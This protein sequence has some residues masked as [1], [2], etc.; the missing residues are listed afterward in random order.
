MGKELLSEMTSCVN[1]KKDAEKIG[2]ATDCPEESICKDIA[3]DLIKQ[4][5]GS[6]CEGNFIALI[7]GDLEIAKKEAAGEDQ[8]LD[9]PKK[10]CEVL[11]RF[12][13]GQGQCRP[14]GTMNPELKKEM[15]DKASEVDGMGG[16]ARNAPQMEV[17][18]VDDYVQE[19][20]VTI[21]LSDGSEPEPEEA[22]ED[23]I[24]QKCEELA[25]KLKTNSRRL[26]DLGVSDVNDVTGT[27]ATQTC[28]ASDE[29]CQ[30]S[31]LDVEDNN[32]D[33]GSSYSGTDRIAISFVV[34]MVAMCHIVLT[35]FVRQF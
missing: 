20:T 33:G 14:D 13:K 19:A 12:K 4:E 2:N 34:S 25:E 8:A 26:A 29:S 32:G 1:C 9:V 3:K 5:Y 7:E 15:A 17:K 24:E 18:D 28:L 11:I 16:A 35:A 22:T 31:D 30:S 21:A 23:E 27:Q 6:D 10:G